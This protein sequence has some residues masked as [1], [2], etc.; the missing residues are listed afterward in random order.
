MNNS[1]KKQKPLIRLTVI[2]IPTVIIAA[3][4]LLILNFN[5]VF[6]STEG[7]TVGEWSRTRK[8]AYSK[9]TYTEVYTFDSDGSGT[10]SFTSPDGYSSKKE[11]TWFITPTKTLVIDGHIKYK[12]NPDYENYYNE[13]DKTAKKHWFVTKHNLY[14]GQS[15]SIKSEVY[16]R[17]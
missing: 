17:R 6:L 15:T 5:G 1:A 11:F 8:G 16:D 3:A 13:K 4:A 9:G 14:I 12:W 7:K 10:K 2:I